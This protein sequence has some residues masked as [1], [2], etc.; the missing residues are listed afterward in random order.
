MHREAV[1]NWFRHNSIKALLLILIPVS[2]SI[3][4][5]FAYSGFLVTGTVV[6]AS[7]DL[8]PLRLSIELDKATFARNETV[9][10]LCKLKNISNEPVNI[11]FTSFC[12]TNDEH[13]PDIYPHSAYFDLVIKDTDDKIVYRWGQHH[14]Y[15]GGFFPFTVG[16][17]EERSTSYVWNQETDDSEYVKVPPGLYKITAIMPPSPSGK[18]DMSLNGQKV[19]LEIPPVVFTISQ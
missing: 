19:R 9:T 16:L 13:S 11:V 2:A 1:A 3:A 12:Y 5:V 17:G 14:G 7:A 4:A 15:G 8:Y 10:V 18:A 6:R